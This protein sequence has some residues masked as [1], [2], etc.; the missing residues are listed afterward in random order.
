M[1]VLWLIL[2]LEL[3]SYL[4]FEILGP[5]TYLVLEILDLGYSYVVSLQDV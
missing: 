5:G 3:G 2:F 1:P 4:S